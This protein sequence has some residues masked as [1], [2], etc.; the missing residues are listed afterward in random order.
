MK[1]NTSSKSQVRVLQL[2]SNPSVGGT[3][4]FVAAIVPQLCCEGL[5]VSVA[6]L[7]ADSEAAVLMRDANIDYQELHGGRRLLGWR[8][9]SNLR[10]FL[11]I[12]KF[13]VICAYGLR[14]SLLLRLVG[15]SLRNRPVLVTGLRG[16][17][18]WRRLHHIVIDRLTQNC[19]DVFIGNS[20]AVCSI[21]KKRE[22]TCKEKVVCIPNGIDTY[23]FSTHNEKK[24]ARRELGISE[25]LLCLTIANFRQEKG[26]LFLLD[27]IAALQP[28][29]E[30]V[31]FLW[32]GRGPDTQQLK[33]KAYAL[34][35]DDIIIFHGYDRNV[36]PFLA[37]ADI[38]VLPS[39]EE[40][41]PRALM[42]AMSMGLPCLAT[43]VGGSGEVLREGTDGFLVPWGDVKNFSDRLSKLIQNQQLRTY[44]GENARL[45]I[46]ETFDLKDIGRQYGELFVELAENRRKKCQ[47]LNSQL[48]C[49]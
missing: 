4:T 44:F 1:Q 24:N 37:S 21:R 36:K 27:A 11:K 5:E 41:M 40:G 19:I 9:F 30:N 31:R 32:V 22:R 13:D 17:D 33:Q 7:W 47:K 48:Y 20:R 34:G 10:R 26:Y 6:N 23:R 8:S 39:K 38:F 49:M 12:R 29:P 28:L 3:E 45:R 15:H 25:C 43:D 16:I 35:L 18:S 14:T 2:L 46:R 42:E